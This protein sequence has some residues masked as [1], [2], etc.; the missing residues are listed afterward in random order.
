M[1]DLPAWF[2]RLVRQQ[3]ARECLTTRSSTMVPTNKTTKPRFAFWRKAA[4]T[5]EPQSPMD[6]NPNEVRI[7]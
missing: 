4:P 6:A 1:P 3:V 7:C 5:T 2:K